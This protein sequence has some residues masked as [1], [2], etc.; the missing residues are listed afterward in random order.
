MRLWIGSIL[1]VALNIVSPFRG[2]S[3]QQ[4][5]ATT[6]LAEMRQALGGA[7]ALDGVKTF[8][9]S[10]SR[11]MSTPIGSKRMA[12]EWFAILPDHFLEVRRDSLTGPTAIE[13]TY[14][15]GIAAGRAF[16]KTD[17]GGVLPEPPSYSDKSPAAVAARQRAAQLHQQ[18]SIARLMLVLFGAAPADQ[19]L[20]F[21]YAGVEQ[22][23]GKNYDVV[24]VT[25]AADFRCRL[26]VDSV[27]RLPVMLT[28]MDE[29]PYVVTTT[30]TTTVTTRNGQVVSQ[31]PPDVPRPPSIPPGNRGMAPKR[32]LFSDFKAQD[33]ITWPRVIEEE[34]QGKTDEIRLGRVRINPKIDARKFDIK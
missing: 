27:T 31:S 29:I 1:L 23:D 12:L 30:S 10:G 13:I 32:W 22:A 34:F 5:D 14:Y 25:G 18:H 8:S 15:S 6:V 24:N 3:A 16:R 19:P 33:G 21:E 26:H 20:Q 9:A 28:W 2:V 11:T 17:S 4:R 7:A